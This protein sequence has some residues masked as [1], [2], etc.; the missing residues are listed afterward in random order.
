MLQNIF[1]FYLICLF[2]LINIFGYGLLFQKIFNK[3]ITIQTH[4][5]GFF[6]FIIIFLL[7]NFIHFFFPLNQNLSLIFFSAGTLLFFKFFNLNKEIIK[8]NYILPIGLFLLVAL[9]INFHDDRYWY[10]LPYI[11]Y[12]QNYKIIFGINSLNI[13]FYSNSIYE[14][15]SIFNIQFLSNSILYIIP[16]SII[17]F[18]SFFI[19]E[20][21]KINKSNRL[22]VLLTFFL[23]LI[24]IRYTRSKEYG[25]DLFTM[26][27]MFLTAYYSFK[28]F[29]KINIENIFKIYC[30]FIFSIFSK[31]YSIFFIFYP[32]FFFFTEFKKT[33][34]LFKKK[35]IFLFFL[36]LIIV[37]FSKN[38]IQSSCLIYPIEKLCFPNNT[39]YNGDKVI[40]SF[41]IGGEAI[42]KGFKNYIYENK[43]YKLTEEEFLKKNK[44][45]YFKY[46]ILDKD[47]ERIL[48]AIFIF[49]L[50]YFIFFREIKFGFNMK[51]KEKLLLSFLSFIFWL[52]YLP[53]S[54]YGGN[55]VILI[56][57]ASILIFFTKMAKL[58]FDIISRTFV[59]FCIVFFVTKN[60][61][62]INDQIS[63]SR[64]NGINFPFLDFNDFTAK[65]KKINKTKILVSSDERYCV[66]SK[67]LCIANSIFNSI[68]SI[69]KINT[70]I[71]VEP[72]KNKIYEALH[73]QNI[74]HKKTFIDYK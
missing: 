37:P 13:F 27:F 44:F 19:L 25:A 50:T 1:F 31:I 56:F 67:E 55:I 15:M 72:D 68:K 65:Q 34:Q 58:K 30:F 4:E 74:D 60:L 41:E 38:Y 2:F 32:L 51:H 6:G 24:L 59:T 47:F 45:S 69:K 42:A 17:F 43:D 5:L 18:V 73:I 35:I 3:Y 26:T 39:W 66:N 12:Y 63:Y 14:I 49:I 10:H 54:R 62:R 23:V 61:L 16:S 33:I 52:A 48:I 7:S 53:Q 71:F 9:T 28:N 29:K 22:N 8:I 36:I 70:Y 20:E 11:N 64:L 40:K 21:I 46:L 57:I